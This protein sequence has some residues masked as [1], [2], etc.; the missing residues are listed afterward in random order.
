MRD[1]IDKLTLL[2]SNGN[3]LHKISRYFENYG[4]LGVKFEYME[5]E[6]KKVIGDID[7]LIG[8]RKLT[9]FLVHVDIKANEQGQLEAPEFGD[10]RVRL[11]IEPKFK[12]NPEQPFN[13]KLSSDV[14]YQS[15]VTI[16]NRILKSMGFNEPV[17]DDA[18]K[19]KIK[20]DIYTYDSIVYDGEPKKLLPILNAAYEWRQEKTA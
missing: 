15:V 9:A 2:E 11:W 17:I 13:S 8:D 7:F 18:D 3:N 14:D 16:I 20:K 10:F 5:N 12:I 19:K 1:L 6:P 4:R